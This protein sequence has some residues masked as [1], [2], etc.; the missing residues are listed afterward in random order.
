MPV[1]EAAAWRVIFGGRGGRWKNIFVAKAGQGPVDP[2]DLLP[3]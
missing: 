1:W 2:S 3:K